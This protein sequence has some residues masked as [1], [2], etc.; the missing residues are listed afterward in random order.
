[1]NVGLLIP[2]ARVFAILSLVSIGGV[3]AVLPEI[4]RQVVDVQ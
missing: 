3:N 4:R 1:M 2:I